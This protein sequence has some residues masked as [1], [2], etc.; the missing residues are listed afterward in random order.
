[1]SA[2]NGPAAP[3]G[4]AS[5]TAA[6]LAWLA[7]GC[8]VVAALA[9]LVMALVQGWQVF[10]RYVLNASPS[11]TEPVALLLM[12]FAMMFGAAAGVRARAHFGFFVLQDSV[13]AGTRRL[14]QAFSWLVAAAISALLA[15]WSARLVA[16][17]WDIPLAG[18]PLPAGLNYLPL[19]VGGALMTVFA[20][21]N[22][23]AAW[24]ASPADARPV[25][26]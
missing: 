7:H 16:D 15:L 25:E 18:A 11:W 13:G 21:E 9:L 3:T 19:A 14:L 1:M 26:H 2:G 12:N 4:G 6:P 24:R 5:A 8:L 20:L 10:A 17:G 22:L 23:L